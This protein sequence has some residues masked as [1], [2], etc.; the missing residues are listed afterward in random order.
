[1]LRLPTFLFAGAVLVGSANASE[2]ASPLVLEETI[3]LPNVSGRIDH[4]AIDLERGHLFIAELGNGTVDVVDLRTKKSSARILGLDEPQ[5]IAYL[6]TLNLLVVACGG[7]GAVKFYDGGTLE[8]KGVVELQND[9][10]NVRVD[11]QSGKV[12]VGYGDGAIA[13]IDPA[14]PTKVADIPL[15]GHPEGFQLSL[16]TSR[17]YV[18]VPDVDEI[19]VLDFAATTPVGSWKITDYSSN[20]PMANLSSRQNVAVAFRSPA[21]IALF[22]VAGNRTS[23]AKT[24]GDAD[25]LFFDEKRAQLYVTCG[26]GLVETFHIDADGIRAIGQTATGSGAR[27]SLFVTELDRL[28]VAVPAGW[29]GSDASVQVLRP[30]S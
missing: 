5:G 19:D 22:D 24:C 25:D 15:P 3:P 13:V 6:A 1:M 21:R 7:D 2:E 17:I 9:A 30:S 14:G 27:T 8:E 23:E 26:A 4:L 29:L 18:N 12:L 11:P 20:F 28:Y 10:D 16:A